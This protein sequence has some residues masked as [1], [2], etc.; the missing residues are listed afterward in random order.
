MFK[1]ESE[2]KSPFKA[3]KGLVRSFSEALFPVFSL[4]VRKDSDFFLSHRAQHLAAFT[5]HAAGR[6]FK[7]GGLAN[8]AHPDEEN[9][10]GASS[11]CA[12]DAGAFWRSL[13]FQGSKCYD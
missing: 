8:W 4:D 5:S 12:T 6:W 1:R 13:R 11:K 7:D 10:M 3:Q 2:I 9:A